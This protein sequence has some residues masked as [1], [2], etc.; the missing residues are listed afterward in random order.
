MIGIAL[1]FLP[2]KDKAP[3]IIASGSGFIGQRII[4]IAQKEKIPIIKDE[5]LAASMSSLPLGTEIPENLY[6]AVAGI[7]SFIF[8]L[9]NHKNENYPD[10]DK[11][12]G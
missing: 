10:P 9:E 11:A 8:Q 3:V 4:E 2:E 6:L 12:I 5:K 1:R 7:F